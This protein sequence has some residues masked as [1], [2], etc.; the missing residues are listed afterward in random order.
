MVPAK[1]VVRPRLNRQRVAE[2][3]IQMA[4]EA[5][6]DAVSLRKL[7]QRLGVTPMALYKHVACKDELEQLIAAEL[8]KKSLR[9]TAIT[10]DTKW[11]TI[12]RSAA[13]DLRHS[14]LE[15]P[16]ILRAFVGELFFLKPQNLLIQEG[17]VAKI[18]GSQ[19]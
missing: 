10:A 16:L 2:V 18:G 8:L 15:H 12:I 5:S 13:D 17:S 9:P 3:A 4:N 7:A 1:P 11:E 6:V 14:L 19:R